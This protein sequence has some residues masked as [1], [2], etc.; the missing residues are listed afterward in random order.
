MTLEWFLAFLM[1]SEQ[2]TYVL[3]VR[4]PWLNR[5]PESSLLQGKLGYSEGHSAIHEECCNLLTQLARL[6]F[7][8]CLSQQEGLWSS[9]FK[10]SSKLRNEATMPLVI[11]VFD[12]RNNGAMAS[13]CNAALLKAVLVSFLRIF[14]VDELL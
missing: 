3:Q 5:I 9:I 7:A 11:E 12:A 2:G 4:I 10:D 8:R 14:Y 6:G 1:P 13:T